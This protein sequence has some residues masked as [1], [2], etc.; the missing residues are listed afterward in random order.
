[1]SISSVALTIR[2][3]SIHAPQLLLW[4]CRATISANELFVIRNLAGI[5]IAWIS[6]WYVNLD[7][8][9]YDAGVHEYREEGAA[10]SGGAASGQSTEAAPAAQ[11]GGYSSAPRASSASAGMSSS[12]MRVLG[13]GLKVVDR[14]SGKGPIFVR[15]PPADAPP[16]AKAEFAPLPS[17]ETFDSVTVEH[18]KEA[19]AK[20]AARRAGAA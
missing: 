11:A 10:A 8:S 5:S 9:L 20:V 6:G 1:M 3:R 4:T 2:P 18:A 19:F 7:P 15:E 16:G 14:K 17:G 12:S 13:E